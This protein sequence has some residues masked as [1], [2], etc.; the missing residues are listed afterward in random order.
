MPSNLS[1]PSRGLHRLIQGGQQ[2]WDILGIVGYAG[3]ICHTW[4]MLGFMPF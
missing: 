4:I 3:E 2:Y 1:H